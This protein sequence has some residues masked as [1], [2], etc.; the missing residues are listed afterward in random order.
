MFYLAHAT[1]YVLGSGQRD[2]ATS[3]LFRLH[4]V[5]S[6]LGFRILV[7]QTQDKIILYR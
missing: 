5:A 4:M 7:D 3:P 1:M 6:D 2:I